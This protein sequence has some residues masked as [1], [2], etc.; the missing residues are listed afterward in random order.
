MS[1]TIYKPNSKNSGCAFSFRYGIQDNKEPCLYVSA[2]QQHSWDQKTKTGNFASNANDFSKNLKIKFNEFECG[3]MIS[4]FKRR[5]EYNTFHTFEDNKTTIKIS[6][7]DKKIKVSSLN[8]STKKIEEKTRILP[9]FGI[10]ITR[11]G[12]DSFKI[13]LEPGE[14]EVLSEFI[15]NLISRIVDFRINSQI[16]KIKNS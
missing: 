4:C 11:N 12:A 9:A 3:S 16:E 13:S 10:S 6:P 5:Y 15:R 7:W 1:I 2:I 8:S 14:V